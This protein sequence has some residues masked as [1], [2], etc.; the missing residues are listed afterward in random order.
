MATYE[1]KEEAAI[2]L[3]KEKKVNTLNEFE[4][5]LLIPKRGAKLK[6]DVIKL[7]K[8]LLSGLPNQ[9][10]VTV[11]LEEDGFNSQDTASFSLDVVNSA[12][13]FLDRHSDY[14]LSRTT[15]S[16]KIM[17]FELGQGGPAGG[18]RSKFVR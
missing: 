5:Y 16:D 7:L 12:Y 10:I 11:N 3:A 8:I 18:R 17:R 14:W 13:S 1:T 4:S 2:R 9:T 6:G 15:V